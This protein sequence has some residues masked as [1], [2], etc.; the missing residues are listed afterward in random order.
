MYTKEELQNYTVNLLSSDK[1]TAIKYNWAQVS[2]NERWRLELLADSRDTSVNLSLIDTTRIVDKEGFQDKGV[3][4]SFMLESLP[5]RN[6]LR[7][8]YDQHVNNQYSQH[9]NKFFQAL[10]EVK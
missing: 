8:L 1:V 5:L 4:E 2:L 10:K 6:K 9:L 3:V 7:E